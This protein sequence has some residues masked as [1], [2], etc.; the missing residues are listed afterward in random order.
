MG[1]EYYFVMGFSMILLGL[2]I[3]LWAAVLYCIA[4]SIWKFVRLLPFVLDW[5]ARHYLYRYVLPTGVFHP[6][7]P[8][9][10]SELHSRVRAL[11]WERYAIHPYI[12]TL[13]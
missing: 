7:A 6:N 11:I 5:R 12:T 10:P 13:R 8:M 2:L 9:C 3:G 1:F 4:A